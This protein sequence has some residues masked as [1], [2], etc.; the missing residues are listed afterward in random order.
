MHVPHASQ[1]QYAAG[2]GAVFF[3]PR[4]AAGRAP[5]RRFSRG[6]AFTSFRTLKDLKFLKGLSENGP[7]PAGAPGLIQK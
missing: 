1:G 6:S 4:H 5:M 7:T 2:I 3:G